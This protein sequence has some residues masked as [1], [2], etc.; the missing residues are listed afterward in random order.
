VAAVLSGAL[1]G[2]APAWSGSRSDL[3]GALN[4]GGRAGTSGKASRLVRQSLVIFEIALA[5][6]V[7]IGSG[8]LIRSFVQLRAANP[9]FDPAGVLTLR[10][11]LAGM[12]NSSPEQ[13]IAFTASVLER[14]TGASRSAG[15]SRH[16][17]PAS[18]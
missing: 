13:R 12:R 18:E 17:R 16:Q 15:C 7:L 11:P 1:F 6:V 2:I 8:L 10:M 4:E 5:V 9:G 3:N 14:I